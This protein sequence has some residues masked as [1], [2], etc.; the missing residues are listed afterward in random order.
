MREESRG[1]MP[2][3][4]YS[5]NPCLASV[6]IR[7]TRL[8]LERFLARATRAIRNGETGVGLDDIEN[9]FGGDRESILPALK[10]CGLTAK[11]GDDAIV[12]SPARANRR[13]PKKIHPSPSKSG[14][15]SGRQRERTRG[16]KIDPQNP[17]AKLRH[18]QTA[19]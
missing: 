12:L 2:R 13:G 10:S 6:R 14:A 7:R 4:I 18:L 9:V 17:F 19:R 3:S 15:K 5:R 11:I 1:L 16:E 8:S